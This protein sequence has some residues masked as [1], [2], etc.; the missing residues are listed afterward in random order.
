M[1]DQSRRA[2][3][4]TRQIS[5]CGRFGGQFH[6]YMHVY[7]HTH[8]CTVNAYRFTNFFLFPCL[9]NAFAAALQP[10]IQLEHVFLGIFLSDEK[11]IWDH[12]FHESRIHVEPLVGIETCS[13][14]DSDE[15]R[16]QTMERE[17]TANE[18][19]TRSLP[20]LKTIRWSSVFSSA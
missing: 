4:D 9:K 7:M 3:A 14:C 11:L 2:F 12:T 17:R 13:L 6:T 10:L 19:L 5:V 18:V 20:G 16:T 1:L 15:A 8:E